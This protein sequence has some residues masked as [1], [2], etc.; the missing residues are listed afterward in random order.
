MIRLKQ[1]VSIL[2]TLLVISFILTGSTLPGISGQAAVSSEQVEAIN[3]GLLDS[4]VEA[5]ARSSQCRVTARM[6]DPWGNAYAFGYD[7]RKNEKIMDF[8][9]SVDIGS[10]TKMFTAAS[11]LQL[12]EQGKFTL[13]SRLVD[14]L[15][16]EKGRYGGL[17]RFEDWDYTDE[18]R[19]YHLLN[20]TSG[21]PD[22]FFGDDETEIKLHGDST[23]QFTPAQLVTLADRLHE[24]ELEPGEKFSYSN[25]NYILLGLIIEKYSGMTY[26][27]YVRQHILAPLQMNNTYFSSLESRKGRAPGHFKGQPAE[28]PPTMAW[29]AGDIVS[30]LEDMTIFIKAW[31]KGEVF[32]EKK[33]IDLLKTEH[34]NPMGG[35]ISYGLGVI[36]LLG[37]SRGH[38][39]QTF[40]FTAYMAVTPNG[41]SFA[42][43]CDDASA[44]TWG[45]AMIISKHISGE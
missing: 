2:T 42:L 35:G 19:L 37:L 22:Y 8:S 33:T 30:T 43:G 39:G 4:L 5:H 38:G 36:N 41:A 34:F 17:L 12:A 3:P 14:L 45:P 7:G 21:F 15:P 29:S 16:P 6:V 9:G 10:C 20:H 1:H 11:I 23:L 32:E 27:Q 31:D 28:M 40:G 25:V 18:V 26:Q 24:P 44:D 13:E